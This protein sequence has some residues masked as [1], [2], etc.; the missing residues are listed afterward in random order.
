MILVKGVDGRKPF[1]EEQEKAILKELRSGKRWPCFPQLKPPMLRSLGYHETR[2]QSSKEVQPRS[3]FLSSYEV[4]CLFATS[5]E[6][7]FLFV[8]FKL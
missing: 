2:S 5:D 4:F 3:E 6:N 1:N 7:V 8:K